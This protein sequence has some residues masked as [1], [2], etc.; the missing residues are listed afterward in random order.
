LAI[1]NQPVAA[2]P[3]RMPVVLAPADYARWLGREPDRAT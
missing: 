3:D 1:L 2:M